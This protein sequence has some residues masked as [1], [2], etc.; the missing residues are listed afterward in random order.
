MHSFLRPIPRPRNY[1]NIRKCCQ[2]L[3]KRF[4]FAQISEIFIL[5][6]SKPFWRKDSKLDCLLSFF[7]YFI[8]TPKII[9]ENNSG[10]NTYVDN[11]GIVGDGPGVSVG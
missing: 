9:I 4:S 10:M 8:T 5:A 2:R 6:E 3:V 1:S 7:L 11:S